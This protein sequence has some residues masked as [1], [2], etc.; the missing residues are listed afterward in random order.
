M[1]D[2]HV[3]GKPTHRALKK[4][5]TARAYRMLA[6]VE[7]AEGKGE[8]ARTCLAKAVDAPPDPA[9]LCQSTGE[10]R[11]AWSAFGPD[12]RFDSLRWGKPS[13]I[14]PMLGQERALVIPPPAPA[15]SEAKPPVPATTVAAGGPSGAARTAEVV[16]VDPKPARTG[17]GADRS[18]DTSKVDAA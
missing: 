2:Y 5:P 8:E 6:E 14:V 17:S 7:Q 16:R 10:V 13:K 18:K 11:A 4:D 12:G 3:I 1:A 9:W 15:K